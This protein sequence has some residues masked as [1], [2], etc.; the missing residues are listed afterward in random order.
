MDISFLPDY[1]GLYVGVDGNLQLA[2]IHNTEYV[3]V[4]RGAMNAY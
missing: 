4:R 2:D 3:I 1:V